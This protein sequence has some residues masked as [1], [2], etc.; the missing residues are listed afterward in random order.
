[1]G[2]V[3]RAD[4]LTLGQPVALKFLPESTAHDQA[5]LERFHNEVRIARRISH[6][7]VCR[8]YDIGEGDS[9][10]FLSME[11]VDGEDLGSL[12]RRIGRLP[13]DK[14]LEIS[15]KL[16]AG[17]AA[18]HDKG[19]L[20]RDLKPANIMLNGEGEVVIMDFGLAEVAE[21]I[22]QD[23]I[24]FGTPAYMAPEQ[25]SGK[26]VTS[27]SDIYSLG[28][29]LYEIFT[30][31]RAFQAD[32]LGEIVR[33]RSQAPTPA[34]PASLVRDLDPGVERVILRCLEPEPT[35]RPASVLAVAAA[36]PGGDPL[37]AALAAG[38]T[39]SPQMVA[40][41]GEVEGLAPR[42]A[43]PLLVTLF[44]G[45]A[46]SYWLGVRESIYDRMTLDQPPEVL[47][48]RAQEVIT[49]LGYNGPVADTAYG[50]FTNDDFENFV[51][52]HDKP[53]PNWDKILSERPSGLIFWYRSSPQPLIATD[54]TDGSLTPGMVTGQNPPLIKSGMAEIFLDP[55]GRLSYF[56]A[57]PPEREDKAEG[58]KPVDWAPLFAAADLDPAQL[59]PADP[60]WNSL[61]ASDTRAAWT[62]TWP[63]NDRPLRVEAAA[64]HGKPVFFAL[65]GPW[66]V[67]S[68]LASPQITAGQKA[69]GIILIS[70][71][72]AAMLGAAFFAVRN[73]RKK[74]S[75]AQGAFRLAMFMFL[76]QMALWIF[77]SHLTTSGETFLL[78]I[79]A[80]STSLYFA[81]LVALLY[82]GLEPYVRRRWPQSMIS[83]SRLLLGRWRDPLVGRDVLIGLL[84]GTGWVF[85]FL[86]YIQFALRWGGSPQSG[87]FEFLSGARHAIGAWLARVAGDGV[88]GTLL[89][90]FMIFL[91]RQLLRSQWLAAGA[92]VLLFT[93]MQALKN[94]H[95]WAAFVAFGLVYSIAAITLVRFGLV[96][97]SASLLVTDLVLGVPMTANFSTWFI[98]CTIFVFASVAAMG[99]WAFYT[100]LAGQK[101]WKEELF[102]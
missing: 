10:V 37:A 23:Q 72:C 73:Y 12:L 99:I 21:L 62:G 30:G 77:R 35:A 101:L 57:I 18:A 83:W 85:I 84:L 15:R 81:V 11:Y 71:V 75:D 100:A 36:L 45:L 25:L 3:Y 90:F 50:F 1:M 55:Q 17:L 51:Q 65:T 94:D 95:F 92:F 19:V 46:L 74:R 89:F 8:I 86:V 70:M 13:S 38:E 22:P 33:V 56:E 14:A 79:V 26:E 53:R 7:N 40:A 24:R 58:V 42:I 69:A 41:A 63:G 80:L 66:T 87:N 4:D 88:Q 28:L 60:I 98:G 2:E 47:V 6:P 34:S 43:V 52:E 39:P 9:L 48:H 49:R 61:A 54:Y 27:K 31:K 82:L 91:F 93:T 5:A 29:V 64:L 68:R 20:H 97:L 59:R 76:I 67:A 16:C 96:S 78:M 102:E 32:T 44:I